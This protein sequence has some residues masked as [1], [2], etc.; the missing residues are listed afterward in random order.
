MPPFYW[1]VGGR[2][3]FRWLR[4]CCVTGWTS[5]ALH[6]ARSFIESD[7]CPRNG[8]SRSNNTKKRAM[9]TQLYDDECGFIVSAE[10]VLVATI[11]VIG[12]IVGLS[13]IQ[14]AVNSE[15]NDV[16][17]AIGSVNQSYAFSGFHKYAFFSQRLHAFTRGSFFWDTIDDC[18]LNQ[19]AISCDGP[20]R[21]TSKLGG[22]GFGGGYS[23]GGYSGG[24]YG[25]GNYGGTCA[26]CGN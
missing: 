22:Y 17:D 3:P 12:L 15:L 23:G 20:V 9:L 18:D 25:G 8:F 16:A 11:V 7:R 1:Q 21:E 2:F 10:L 5:I 26:A 13:E 19:C 14:H 6:P 4:A 24:S